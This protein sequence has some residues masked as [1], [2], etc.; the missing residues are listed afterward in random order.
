[1]LR[2]VQRLD[3]E[4]S[5]EVVRRD[6]LSSRSGKGDKLLR[7]DAGCHEL[8]LLG[9]P[10][11]SDEPLDIDAILFA[12]A[13]GERL[14]EDSSGNA[15]ANLSLCV[16]RSVIA[17]L[18][19]R[20]AVEHDNVALL[21]GRWNLPEGLPVHWGPSAR[22]RMAHAM[23]RQL[24]P[25][26]EDSPVF[27][28]MGVQGGTRLSVPIEPGSCYLLGA[29]PIRGHSGSVVLE[30]TSGATLVR[31]RSGQGNE[32]TALAFC[33]GVERRA[34]VEIEAYGPGMSWL[35]G[36]WPAGRV[37]LGAGR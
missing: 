9:S 17:K 18:S 8:H 16:G 25:A 5:N 12:V 29:S 32:G 31:S 7:L 14:A 37:S 3:A 28:R 19:F 10:P 33:A 6:I 11:N 4:R 23:G 15:D 24:F 34:Y 35:M 26:L 2:L 13:D 22:A 21:H 30:A 20:G 1:V 36:V 27:S